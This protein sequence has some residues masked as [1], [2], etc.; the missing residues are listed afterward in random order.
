MQLS[1]R[2][3]TRP[4][5]A[6]ALVL[7]AA[8][9]GSAQR[10][11]RQDNPFE[12]PTATVHYAR[13]RD[14]DLK[15]VRVVLDFD[16][17]N[18]SAVGSV[19]HTLAP[20][21]DG[22]K[23]ITFDA[24]QNLKISRCEI[25]G[26]SAAFTHDGDVLH[27]TAPAALLRDKD[28][29]VA[30]AYTL[31]GGVRGGGPNG[32]EGIH[33][34][35]P[36]DT[37]PDRRLAFWTQGETDGN[38]LWVPIYDYPNDKTTSETIVTVPEKWTV[39]GNGVEGRTTRNTAKH[40][41]TF[42]WTMKQPHSTY[43]LSLVAGEFDIKKTAWQGVPLYYVVPKGKGGQ[44]NASFDDTP[45]MLTFFS[46]NLGVKYPWPKYAQSA[47]YDFGG[48]MEN[49]SATTLGAGSLT[50]YR[51]GD[52]TMATLNSHELAHQ[53]F[54]D[55][56]TCK[57]WG[58]IWLNES[59]ATFFEML[60]EEHARGKDAYDAER[61]GNLRSYLF[62]ASS[63]KRPLATKLYS[64]PSVIF[65]AHTYPKGGLILHMLRRELGDADFF[66]G[67]HYYLKQN[68]YTPVESHDLSKA[69]ADATGRNVDA[70]FDQWIYKP[71]H[72]EL[73]AA[74]KYDETTHI[75]TLTVRQTQNTTKGTPIY[76]AP[77]TIGLLHGGSASGVERQTVRLSQA[78][79]DFKFVVASRPDA[80]LVDPDHDLL[81][82][83]KLVHSDAENAVILRTAPCYLDR[84]AA[85]TAIKR[86]S[87][88][89][90][91][92]QW[93]LFADAL[94]AE[95]NE[96]VASALLTTLA[97]TKN[98]AYRALFREQVKS[99][100][101]GRRTAAIQALS[102][103]PAPEKADI[104]LFR[105][106]ALSDKE[107]YEVVEAGLKAVSLTDAAGNLDVFRHQIAAKT[108][109]DRLPSA[110]V[111][112]LIAAKSDAVTPV[113]LEAAAK[114][115]LRTPIRQRAINSFKES[116]MGSEP[117]HNGLLALL[118]EDN[119]ELQITV[120]ETLQERKDTAA[121]PALNALGAATKN[122]KVSTAAKDAAANLGK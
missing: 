2:R 44:I 90:S 106:A 65:D 84:L 38:H 81:K 4:C 108:L 27:I 110:A 112:A 31:P 79:E 100:Q 43:L 116:A 19:T 102:L 103:L 72:P 87:P 13:S 33:W 113:L 82:E 69:I 119:P 68:A 93:K 96:T 50:D 64:D 15:N 105:A 104:A 115:T 18:K 118:K 58:E 80:L 56:V 11:R 121:V 63:Y 88:K 91:D 74:W 37:D 47:M 85:L 3:S 95:T 9:P 35:R 99:K 29:Q 42:R 41:R 45:D 32:S 30:I 7:F 78:S 67:L 71:G 75:V 21:H 40:T 114:T 122:A 12:P 5:L 83:L 60:Y 36:S 17:A 73:E 51:L 16:V 92:A 23:I 111:S 57:D 39:I 62:E 120:I 89:L 61:A 101:P 26:T 25:N 55:Y 24:G 28:V 54:G 22:L 107:M 98:P 109:R 66:K 20:L 48:G 76:D 59:F 10:Q 1:L 49:V 94:T 52:H 86:G 34:I 117:V 46:M 70:F 6:F 53:W 14:Y 97:D 77:L 8:S